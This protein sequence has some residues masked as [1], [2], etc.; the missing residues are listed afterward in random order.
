MQTLNVPAKN[1]QPWPLHVN[2]KA[3]SWKRDYEGGRKSLFSGGP[4]MQS[5]N[6]QVEESGKN[7]YLSFHGFTPSREYFSLSRL[8][9]SDAK[10]F[11]VLFNV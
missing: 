7:A 3:L 11:C 6:E 1:A 4:R 10:G 9:S 8:S 5:I 2:V